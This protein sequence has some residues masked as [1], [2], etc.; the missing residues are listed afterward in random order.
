MP[1]PQK[2]TASEMG[3]DAHY[4]VS[5][6]V[7]LEYC[8]IHQCEKYRMSCP[9]GTPLFGRG[10]GERGGGSGCVVSLGVAVDA[11]LTGTT[12]VCTS[13]N[14]QKKTAKT[15]YVRQ[16]R[17]NAHAA[18]ALE[19]ILTLHPC[20]PPLALHPRRYLPSDMIADQGYVS[21]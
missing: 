2:S 8:P 21:C 9:C 15:E 5:H 11:L 20:S 14:L 4:I 1:T 13:N 7:V 16:Q 18:H 17:A 6:D 12:G 19:Y 3:V 10:K